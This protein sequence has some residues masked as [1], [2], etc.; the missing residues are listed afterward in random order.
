MGTRMGGSTGS[1]NDNWDASRRGSERQQGGDRNWCK[2]VKRAVGVGVISR[3]IM[4]LCRILQ[5][6]PSKDND[7]SFLL[8]LMCVCCCENVVKLISHFNLLHRFGT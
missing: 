8:L 7:C 2:Y 5:H 1:Y 3:A 4:I 6:T